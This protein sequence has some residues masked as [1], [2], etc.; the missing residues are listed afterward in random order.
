MTFYDILG[1]SKNAT[2]D[3]IKRAYRAQIKFFHPD[4]FQENP[5]IAKIKTLQLNEAYAV[6]SDPIK[7]AEYDR[8]VGVDTQREQKHTDAGSRQGQNEQRAAQEEHKQS[9]REYSIKDDRRVKITWLDLQPDWFQ[10]AFKIAQPIFVLAIAIGILCLFP[11]IFPTESDEPDQIQTEEQDKTEL[12]EFTPI[13]KF[14]MVDAENQPPSFMLQNVEL[15]KNGEVLSG[16]AEDRIAPFTINTEGNGYYYVKLKDADTKED[17]ICFFV[18]G[19]KS[20]DVDVPLGTYELVYAYGLE[21]FG[22]EELFG[23]DTSYT[24]ADELFDFTQDETQV[25]G[26]T[27]DLYVQYNGN[28][29]TEEIDASEF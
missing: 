19:G 28:L 8:A 10:K 22:L 6:L 12:P 9:E 26:W 2:L 15:P 23:A 3:E 16:N 7:R 18:Y 27:V 4:V 14:P 13:D 21:W 25:Y 17:V 29:E 11:V 1:V 20:A 5:E 24:K